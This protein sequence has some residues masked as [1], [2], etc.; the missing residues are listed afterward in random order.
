MAA[1]KKRKKSRGTRIPK[2]ATG[3]TLQRGKCKV[4]KGRIKVCV[5]KSGAVSVTG[6]TLRRAGGKSKSAKSA[7]AKSAPKNAVTPK[8]AKKIPRTKKSLKTRLAQ[9]KS[10]LFNN[11]SSKYKACSC[12]IINSK[13]NPTVTP[14]SKTMCAGSK[15]SR[16]GSQAL[17]EW[18]SGGFRKTYGRR[19]KMSEVS[20]F[21]P[22]YEGPVVPGLMPSFAGVSRRSRRRRRR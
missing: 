16:K 17:K 4:V 20:K 10:P 9:C 1:K 2:S 7:R 3:L 22:G 18:R 8:V 19:P 14:L 13:G 6:A 21:G 12:V 15:P 11:K 5:S